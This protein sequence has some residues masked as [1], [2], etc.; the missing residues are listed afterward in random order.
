MRPLVAIVDSGLNSLHEFAGRMWSNPYDPVDGIDNDGNG[1]IDDSR[2]WNFINRNSNIASSGYH[3]H[4]QDVARYAAN[5]GTGFDLLFVRAADRGATIS[6]LSSAVD[7][8]VDLKRRHSLPIV[9]LNISYGGGVPFDLKQLFQPSYDA[10]NNAGILVVASAGNEGRDTDV[11]PHYPSSFSG[12]IGVTTSNA[13]GSYA[14]RNYGRQS[15]ALGAPASFTSYAAPI[16][17]GAIGQFAAQNPWASADQIREALWSSIVPHPTMTS[18]TRSG[19]SLLGPIKFAPAPTP[20]APVPAPAPVPVP[21]SPT[22]YLLPAPTTSSQYPFAGQVDSGWRVSNAFDN[23]RS[24]THRNNNGVNT[25]LTFTYDVPYRIT[26]FIVTSAHD[27]PQYDPTAYRLEGSN[28]GSSWQILSTGGLALPQARQTDSAPVTLPELPLFTQYRLI[29][30]AVRVQ[31]WF[32]QYADVK[33]FGSQGTQPGPVPP[34]PLSVVSLAV[35]P[36]TVPEDGTTNLTYT[37]TRTGSTA[38]ALVVGYG[39]AGTATQGT[40]YTVG[41][42]ATGTITFAAGA[43]TATVTVDPTAD[44]SVESDETVALTLAAGTGY[45]IGTTGAVVGTIANDDAPTTAPL[46]PPSPT[47]YLLPAP[48][49]FNHYPFESRVDSGW[50]VKSAFDNNRSSTHRN[51]NGVNTG[52]AFT[53]DVPTRL[54]SFVV[55]SAHDNPQYDPTAY[56]LEGSNDGSSWQILS[57]G[58]LALPQAR[59]TDSAPVTLPELPLFTQYRLIFTAVRVQDW[60]VQYADVKLF[61]SQV[62]LDSHMEHLLHHMTSQAPF[63]P[64]V[65]PLGAP[66]APAP[67]PI[68]GQP[69]SVT[70]LDLDSS[71]WSPSWSPNWEQVGNAFDNDPATKSAL[72]QYRMIFPTLKGSGMMQIADLE[73]FG[74]T[75]SGTPLFPAALPSHNAQSV[76]QTTTST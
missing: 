36:A 61:G 26:S 17:S 53:Y 31:D 56:R 67:D 39:I 51:N 70:A 48:T 9:A 23:N 19:G 18:R 74:P 16:V 47:P 59:Q 37:F 71:S 1:F 20:P 40:D 41:G 21:P 76:W 38:A 46:S 69:T 50:S 57:T 44:T 11:T 4:G 2:G 72:T 8:V 15:V 13:D 32:V 24:S 14:G 5:Q 68:T 63:S 65:Q 43:A 33:L 55:T 25:G 29:F 30:T 42:G 52:L 10:A 35:S 49:T 60:F 28:D 12:V 75:V 64:V 73:L 6:A 54:T 66:P 62:Q 22:P 27:N 58:G 7:Y 3:S 34:A 45:T